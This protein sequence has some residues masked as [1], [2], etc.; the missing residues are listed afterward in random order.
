MLYAVVC[1]Q[2]LREPVRS[3]TEGVCVC[4]CVQQSVHREQTHQVDTV[5]DADAQ[6][7]VGFGEVND[8]LTLSCD[9]EAGHC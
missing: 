3:L 7:H 4:V 9:G 8:L 2:A 1:L 6:G 5:H